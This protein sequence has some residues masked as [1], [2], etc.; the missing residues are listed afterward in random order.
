MFTAVVTA[1]ALFSTVNAQAA[2]ASASGRVDPVVTTTV[3]NAP[4]AT[5]TNSG[6]GYTCD[7]TKPFGASNPCTVNT[8]PK[9]LVDIANGSVPSRNPLTPVPAS[10]STAVVTNAV[11]LIPTTL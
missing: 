6:T 4:P 9:A 11:K 2:S 3:A 5:T 1:F 7:I 8:P 10:T